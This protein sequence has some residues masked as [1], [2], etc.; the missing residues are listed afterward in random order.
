M[1][2]LD[3]VYLTHC[4]AKKDDSLRGTDRKVTPDE[5][6]TATPTQR[7]MNKCKEEG[8]EWA[9]F[10]DKYGIWFPN[11]KHEWYDKHPNSV[12]EKEFQVLVNDF[13]E[14]LRN[15]D[16]ILFYHN[17]GRFNNLY[18]RLLKESD[19]SERIE[20]FSHKSKIGKH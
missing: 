19:I 15:Y 4:S 6:Y 18:K 20:L 1:L 16:K 5:L 11:E 2:I 13:E 9:I 8:V 17:P 7:F 3:I 10:S 12:T 14:K